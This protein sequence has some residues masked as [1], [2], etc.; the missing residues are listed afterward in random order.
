MKKVFHFR[1]AV[2]I[3]HGSP[4]L[5]IND[6]RVHEGECLSFYG[7]PPEQT[8]ILI[9]EMTGT[10][11]PEEGSVEILGSDSSD[12]PEKNWFQFVEN[13]GI[14]NN[15]PVFLEASSIGENVATQFRLRNEAMEEPQ[16]SAS[17]L[18]AANLVQLT[19]TDLS[20]IMRDASS[21]LRMKVRLSRALAYRP[22]VVLFHDPTNGMDVDTARLF[23]DLIRRTRRRLRYTVVLFT[24]D[25]SLLEQL[26]DRVIF[27]NPL[28]GYFVEN[29]LRG[30]YHKLLPFLK[31]SPAQLFQLSRDI[32]RHGRIIQATKVNIGRE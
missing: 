3:Q 29:Q 30:W 11:I 10:L 21:S 19:I 18:D 7:L 2:R 15:Q 22:R 6:L 25:V 31:P 12:I 28:N 16:L 1:D 24:S 8:E 32:L 17:V 9:S 5:R 14:Y 13:I 20:R 4:V 26:A 23:V 27:L